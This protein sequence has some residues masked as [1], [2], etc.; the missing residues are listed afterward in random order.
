MCQFDQG[1][2]DEVAHVVVGSAVADVVS[3]S[4]ATGA[5]GD[6]V[7]IMGRNFSDTQGSNTVTFS[8]T[9]ATIASWTATKIETTVPA[10]ANTGPLAVISNGITSNTI[11]FTVT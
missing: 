4:V 11:T 9:Q 8:G 5:P 2:L 1:L 7:T 6:P 3:L 10:A